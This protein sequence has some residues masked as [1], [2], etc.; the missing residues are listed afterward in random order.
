MNSIPVILGYFIPIAVVVILFVLFTVPRLPL[1]VF[2]SPKTEIRVALFPFL[3]FTLIIIVSTAFRELLHS[4]DPRQNTI[5]TLALW[6]LLLSPFIVALA[7][8]KQRL[9]SCLLPTKGF[10]FHL[11][12]AGGMG[13]G[14]ILVYAVVLGKASMVPSVMSNLVAVPSLVLLVTAFS[15]EFIFRG[16]LLARLT[17]GIGR[18]RGVLLSAVLFGLI[19]YPRYL[20]SSQLN[21]LQI[22]QTIILII[23]VSIGGGYGVYA[24]R[25]MLYS[26]FIHW[27]MNIAQVSIPT[28]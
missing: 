12:V 24:V 26:V 11:V 20:A 1:P 3:V 6:A 14:A 22:T 5:R 25:C 8:R 9:D 15:E 17:A 18:H 23:A 2:E 16:Y 4:N 21:S 19:H 7:L 13:L 27:C 10:L 28:S